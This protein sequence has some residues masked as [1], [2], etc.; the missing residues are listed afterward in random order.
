[1]VYESQRMKSRKMIINSRD[2]SINWLCR[3]LPMP[4]FGD[5]GI[6]H[7]PAT[8]DVR[9]VWYCNDGNPRQVSWS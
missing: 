7:N 5:C 6:Y 1:M 2:V 3:V 9:P 8:G 4:W